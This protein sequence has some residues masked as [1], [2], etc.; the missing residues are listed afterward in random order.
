MHTRQKIKSSRSEASRQEDVI[1]FS[2]IIGYL[3]AEKKTILLITGAL[4]LVAVVRAYM[5]IPI[6]ST[7]AMLQ[8]DQESRVI[9]GLEEVSQ[10]VAKESELD[11]IKSRLIISEVVD[12]LNLT[13]SITPNYFPYIGA[14]IA[15]HYHGDGVA[16]APLQVLGAYAWG[17]EKL[18]LEQ[19][20][21]TG[22]EDAYHA[23]WQLIAEEDQGFQ[24]KIRGRDVLS[25]RVGEQISVQFEGA[26]ITLR[27]AEL[28]ARPG[29]VFTISRLSRTGM[30]EG[31]RRSIGVQ[32]TGRESGMVMISYQGT[33]AQRNVDIVNGV[34]EAYI[35][36]NREIQTKQA[37]R[38]L[39]FI[40]GQLPDLKARQDAA[41]LALQEFQRE[42]GSVNVTADIERSVAQLET[43]KNELKML[44]WEKEKQQQSFA[45]EHPLTKSLNRRVEITGEQISA[46][47][48]K[49]RKL[50]ERE[51]EFL[52]K[53]REVKAS[54][55]LYMN[56]LNKAQELRI[57]KAGMV[58]NARI[59]DRAEIQPWKVGPDR[60][61]ILA[62]GLL[63]GLLLG[64]LWALLRRLLRHGFGDPLR[65]GKETGLPL[66]A[67]VPMT[68]NQQVVERLLRKKRRG[69][70]GKKPL[71]LAE[72]YHGDPAIEALR[73]FRTKIHSTMKARS[74]KVMLITAPLPENGASFFSSNYAALARGD[75]QRVLLVDGDMRQGKLHNAMD[76]QQSPGL[77]DLIAG[78]ATME[79]VLHEIHANF[80]FIS[81]GKRPRSPTDLLESE[82]FDE[83]YRQ[84]E[85]RFDLV[86]FDMP[87]ALPVTD[88]AI[89]ANRGARVF[90]LFRPRRA[91]SAEILDTIAHFEQGGVRVDGLMANG[92]AIWQ[93]SN[94]HEYRVE[95]DP[96]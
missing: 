66:L 49:L 5:A 38:Q 60:T 12:D 40:E 62:T 74:Q 35:R 16:E 27:V 85:E 88:A 10:G 82:R 23:T 71:L 20:D 25:G 46:L 94:L 43:L 24:L 68:K 95:G 52:Q 89:L 26:T 90:L 61:K 32:R 18:V 69:A 83:I 42:V 31:L 70:T 93:N 55:A 34:A 48:M 91:R 39:E 44:Q 9:P 57:V 92:V 22:V 15:R 56:L 77:A 33:D 41:A 6:Y 17:G 7:E 53:S 50:P 58:G 36:H 54:T 4:F 63:A 47:E 30:V 13:L 78:N 37:A 80:Y 65:I 59:I 11:I 84:L 79:Q 87:P 19:F 2:E 73:G 3:L 8:I 76:R 86:V 1:H 81:C 28:A 14:A 45:E 72:E 67:T 21:V 51:W 29:H 75:R 64:I 96:E